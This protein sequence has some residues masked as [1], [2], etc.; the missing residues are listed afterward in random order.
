M[1]IRS[2]NYMKALVEKAHATKRVADMLHYESAT[3][4]F[5]AREKQVL[6]DLFAAIT[7]RASQG[8]TYLTYT[9]EPVL[10]RLELKAYLVKKGFT[11]DYNAMNWDNPVPTNELK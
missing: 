11:F 7:K 8:F 1:S 3:H 4:V 6:D 5:E 2:A 9:E 10:K